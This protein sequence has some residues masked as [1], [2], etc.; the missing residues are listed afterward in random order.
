[1]TSRSYVEIPRP[2][3]YSPGRFDVELTFP[4]SSRQRAEQHQSS[5]W[6]L[7]RIHDV[8]AQTLLDQITNVQD[9]QVN[10]GPDYLRQRS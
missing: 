3:E 7:A 8:E 10:L 1:M 5:A 2:Y 9:W 4:A 6:K